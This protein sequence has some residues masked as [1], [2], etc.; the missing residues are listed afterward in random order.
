MKEAIFKFNVSGLSE[1]Y[2]FWHI[3]DGREYMNYLFYASFDELLN[4]LETT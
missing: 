3:L 2:N 1:L 4:N